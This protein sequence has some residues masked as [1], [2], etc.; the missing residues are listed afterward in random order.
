MTPKVVESRLAQLDLQL[1][2]VFDVLHVARRSQNV[3]LQ[4]A[5]AGVI[6]MTGLGADNFCVRKDMESAQP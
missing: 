5:R 4:I 6:R 3:S 2:K 1:Y